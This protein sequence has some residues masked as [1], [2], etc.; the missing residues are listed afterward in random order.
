MTTPAE[1]TAMIAKIRQLPSQVEA[2]VKGLNDAQLDTP[3]GEG[4]WTP[5]QVVHHLADSHLNAFIRVK[6]IL[7]EDKPTL[8]PYDQV[9]WANTHEAK[10]LPV[11][12]SLAIIGG[13]HSRWSALLDSVRDTDWQRK[14]QHPERGEMTLDDILRLY[15][16]HGE[17]HVGQI[18][19][20][21]QRK[22]W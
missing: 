1:R 19:G 22:G 20:L 8:K 4:K 3:Y 9:K 14:A 2:A 17:N 15:A 5:R 18:T 12:P 11:A 6:L 7:T 13:L 10:D 21:R 16:H